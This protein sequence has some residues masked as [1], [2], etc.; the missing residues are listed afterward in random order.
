MWH[1]QSLSDGR[2]DPGLD[3]TITP[4][5]GALGVPPLPLAVISLA[6]VVIDASEWISRRHSAAVQI[7]ASLPD[8]LP[9]MD[10]QSTHERALSDKTAD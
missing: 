6:E 9:E 7:L 5:A 1:A 4:I 10:R 2:G 3:A 8:C